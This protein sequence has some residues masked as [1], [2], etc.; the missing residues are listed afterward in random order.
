M[1]TIFLVPRTSNS[2]DVEPVAEGAT[3]S[4]PEETTRHGLDVA[5]YEAAVAEWIDAGATIVGGCCGTR[6]A[7]VARMRALVDALA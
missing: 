6:P 7:H 5:G 3:P 4:E 1:A 2:A